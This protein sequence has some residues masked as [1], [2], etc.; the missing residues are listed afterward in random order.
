MWWLSAPQQEVEETSLVKI[1]ILEAQMAVKKKLAEVKK[2][3]KSSPA[4]SPE[5]ERAPL[6]NPLTKGGRAVRQSLLLDKL[7]QMKETNEGVAV[8]AAPPPSP[9]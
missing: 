4:S 3:I 9:T 8:R 2:M 7:E 5:K 6:V 1:K